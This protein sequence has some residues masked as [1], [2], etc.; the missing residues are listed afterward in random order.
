MASNNL[1]EKYGIKEVADVTLYRIDKKEQTFESQRKISVASILKG[2]LELKTVY[3]LVNGKGAED[4]F[5]AYVFSDAD[6]LT[7]TNYDC[8]DQ[9]TLA[10]SLRVTIVSDESLTNTEIANAIDT[11]QVALVKKAVGQ[12]V[13][14]DSMFKDSVLLSAVD[15]S[16]KIEIPS[17]KVKNSTISAHLVDDTPYTA[18]T[19]V[20]DEKVKTS[21]I[22][23]NLVIAQT[24][25]KDGL[26]VETELGSDL[27][28]T[29][30]EVSEPLTLTTNTIGATGAVV[31]SRV[32]I[33]VEDGDG[34]TGVAT[35]SV[36]SVE[37]DTPGTFILT[38][39]GIS[40][41]TTQVTK[42]VKIKTPVEWTY[43][44]MVDTLIDTAITADLSTGVNAAIGSGGTVPDADYADGIG[45]HEYSYEQQIAMLFARK[46]NLITKTGVR[47]TFPETDTMFG[48]IVFNDNFTGAPHSTEKIVVV[49]LADKFTEG[50]YDTKEIAEYIKSLKVTF[51][52]KS[53][54]VAYENYAEL[55][56]ED[57]MGY[58]RPDFLGYAYERENG[59]GVMTPFEANYTYSDW[60][61][62]NGFVRDSAIA[63]A[64]MWENNE[65][66]SI[67]D[68]IDALKQKQKILDA[69]EPAG[70]KGINSVFGGYKV[71]ADY[72]PD[73]STEDIPPEYP[74]NVY[75]YT[76]DG[77]PI[78]SQ[79]NGENVTSSYPLEDVLGAVED[80]ALA[81]SSIGKSIRVDA[82]PTQASN[83]A[84]YIRVD[85]AVDTSAGSYL[86]LLHNRNYRSLAQDTDGIFQFEDKKG[87]TLYYQDKIFKGVEWLALVIIGTK[88]MIFVVNR[89]GNTNVERVAWMVN[90]NGYI[91]NRRAAMLVRNG[92][93]HTTDITVNDETFEATCSVKDLTVRKINKKTNHYVPVL[94]LDTLK[95]STL[96]QTAEEVYAQGGHG[97]GRLIGWDFNKEIT[98]T[99]QDALFTPASMSA[100]F[101]S[102]EGNDFR[103]GVKE[104]KS[105]D[106]MEKV[107]AKRSFIVPAGNSNGTPSE[108]DKTAQAVFYDPNTMEPYP[109]GTPIAEGEIFY[110]WTRSIAYE[111]QSIGKTI[112]ISADKFPGTYKVVGETYVRSKDT[113]DDERFQFVVPQ[114][115]MTSEQTITLEA[116]GDP[117][118]NEI[119]SNAA[120]K[121]A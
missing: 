52:A 36:T 67:N 64:R 48:D 22:S 115:K 55:V 78:P 94:F 5:E 117:A 57:E 35:I 119:L 90:E 83:R 87:N 77:S 38:T 18:V 112:E 106:R 84:I 71:S 85:G 37:S 74:N 51:D 73:V 1:F 92:L 63:I 99:M 70:L 118:V 53:Y 81:E 65:H 72:T 62:E 111:G 69:S 46:Q 50:T 28:I 76:V 40:G 109:D 19:E 121:I 80:I 14:L 97:N 47:Y 33:N 82:E 7:G 25:D 20:V 42:V 43:T 16:S 11:N 116:D 21:N 91:D 60:V 15:Y 30:I 8:D 88:G 100:I 108:A 79:F 45:T 107:T 17:I 9:N 120:V 96:E 41:S 39:T 61:D 101:G 3:P 66:Y 114:A 113:G 29:S 12:T 86:Y 10:T 56:V 24:N 27:T 13:N 102:Y 104:T 4:G 89:H 75:E 2:A 6:V 23:Y 32:K 103:K 58:F 98:L 26:T 105:I 93:I 59:V 95:V 68:A 34:N 49:G 44:A 110:K 31:G 54:N